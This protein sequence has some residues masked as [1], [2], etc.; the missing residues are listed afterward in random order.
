MTP[1]GA[2][3]VGTS[4]DQLGTTP[5]VLKDVRAGTWK[6]ELRLDGYIP[7]PLRLAV[8]ANQTNLIRTN[9]VNWQ[10]AE[11]MRSARSYLAAH[12]YDRAG[13]GDGPR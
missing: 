6:G 3:V 10:Y 5:L 7:V 8:N 13:G 4:G 9:L 2:T 12:D 1:S 11:A